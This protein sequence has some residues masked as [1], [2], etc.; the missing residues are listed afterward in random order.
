MIEENDIFLAQNGNEISLEKI[1]KEYR[2][3]LYNNSKMFFLKGGDREDLIQEGYIGLLKAIKSFDK[4]KNVSFNTF[5]N[6]CIRRQMITAI[7]NYNSDRHKHLNSAMLE[8]GYSSLEETF[9]YKSSSILFN[10]PEDI[11]LNKELLTH[12][13]NFLNQNLSNFE[14]KVFKYLYQDY[15]Y[16]EISNILEENSKKVDNAMQRIK[17]KIL[18]YFSIYIKK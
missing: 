8:T 16:T 1:I 14:K 3:I 7:K 10:S 18:S 12:L 15:S 2:S 5:A 6:L 11:I 4:S 13:S 9:K 17:R